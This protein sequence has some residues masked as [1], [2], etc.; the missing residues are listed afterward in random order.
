[1]QSTMMHRPLLLDEIME[2]AATEFADIE[3]VSQLADKSLHRYTYGEMVARAKRLAQALLDAR[4]GHGDRVAT[5]CWNHYV[6]LEAYFGIPAM[7]GVCHMVN[8]RLAADDIA[9]IIN[10]AEDRILIVDDV[11]LPLY[12]QFKDQI[13]VEKV[14]VVSLTDQ[15]VPD[16]LE[17]FEDFLATAG[18][19]F[20]YPDKDENAACGMC[21]TSG[22]TGRPKGVVYSHRSTVLHAIT[23]ALPDMLDLS[24]NDTVLPV[25]PMF[26]VNAWGL[27]YV[28]TLIGAKQ[29]FP[30]P[31]LDAESLL[32]LYTA[33]NVNVSAGVPTIWMGILEALDTQ[34]DRWALHPSLRMTV[35]GSAAPESMLRRFDGHGIEL[36]QA[37]GMTETSPLGTAARLKPSVQKLSEDERYARRATVGSTA[38]LVQIRI[39]GDDGLPQPRDGHSMGELQIRGH[40][41]AGDYY[42]L[43]TSDD[44]FTADGWLR[45]GDI[46]TVDADGYVTITDRTKDVIKSGGEWI[47]SVALENTLMGHEDVAEAAVVARPD[48]KWGERPLAAVVVH[49]GAQL[50]ADTLRA[51]LL[52]RMPKWQVPDD[53]VFIDAIPRTSTG[54]FSKLD[55]RRLL[56]ETD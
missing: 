52:E 56:L 3:V 14:L 25:V 22:T 16:G 24:Y 23:A 48:D 37:W 1:M 38:P 43:E 19:G 12:D 9:W 46:A 49:D 53:Y 32:D 4:V 42:R 11:L 28:A 21:Y 55:L 33:E 45:T 36:I 41:I 47:S 51:Y 50:E 18:D 26:H 17:R 10:H 31:H 8:I 40:W 15:P 20:I 13:D 6:H 7:G 30:G 54:K 2:R 39:M 34:P 5:L 29:V 44:K 35:G 27:P